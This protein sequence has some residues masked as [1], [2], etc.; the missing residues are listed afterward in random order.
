MFVWVMMEEMR[1]QLVHCGVD[2][3][4]SVDILAKAINNANRGSNILTR[5]SM[6][7]I[8][9]YQPAELAGEPGTPKDQRA[10]EN[11][12]P[13]RRFR[14]FPS[15]AGYFLMNLKTNVGVMLK[16]INDALMI[17]L[18]S[19]EERESLQQRAQ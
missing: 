15:C 1:D 19:L 14:I 13:H 6:G 16:N 17:L 11:G 4:L 10:S 2:K 7:R 18:N 12:P 9:F 3:S 8:N 5:T